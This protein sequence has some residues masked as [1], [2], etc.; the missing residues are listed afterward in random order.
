MRWQAHHVEVG[1]RRTRTGFL[2]F[3][4]EINGEVRWLEWATWREVAKSDWIDIEWEACHWID[5]EP[6]SSGE[7]V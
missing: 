5:A 6:A 7:G 3:P 4:K 1:D 2:L